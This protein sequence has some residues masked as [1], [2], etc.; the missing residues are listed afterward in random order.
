MTKIFVIRVKRLEPATCCVGD[1]DVTRVPAIH[2]CETGSLNRA[3]FMIY[4]IPEFAEFNE[5]SAPFS[6]SSNVLKES[7]S[8]GARGWGWGVPGTRSFW[9]GNVVHS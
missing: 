7:V 6:N 4:Q 2:T 8:H 3:K 9:A 1:Q 5:S